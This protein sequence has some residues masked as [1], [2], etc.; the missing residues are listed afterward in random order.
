LSDASDILDPLETMPSN[1]DVFVPVSFPKLPVPDG[2]T[3][4]PSPVEA[5]LAPRTFPSEPDPSAPG[6]PLA[7]PEPPS[8]KANQN[9]IGFDA[10][11]TGSA[12]F[13]NRLPFKAKRR[14][15]SGPDIILFIFFFLLPLAAGIGYFAFVAADQYESEFRF[16]VV[17]TASATPPITGGL[18]SVLGGTGLSSGNTDSYTVTDFLVSPQAVTEVEKKLPLR[19]MFSN[20]QADWLFRLNPDVPQEKLNKYWQWMVASYYDPVTGIASARVRAFTA[21]DAH[22]IANALLKSAEALVNEMQERQRNDTIRFAQEALDRDNASLARIRRQ[23]LELRQQS[24][25]IE[26]AASGVAENTALATSLRMT[27]VTDQTEVNALR[28]VIKNDNAPM[29][30]SLMEKIE[31]AKEQLAI[32]DKEISTKGG[33]GPLAATVGKFDDLNAEQGIATSMMASDLVTL[34]QARAQADQQHIYLSA[35]VVPTNPTSSGFPDRPL[36]IA[37]TILSAF[38]LFCFVKLV[39]TAIRSHAI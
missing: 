34:Q 11:V 32:I 1:P 3:I 5:L 13:S 39:A 25:Y 30:R 24:G 23:M 16:N 28:G 9:P 21:S 17:D 35:Y 12:Q 4:F 37:L 10:T 33:S 2:S 14:W 29:I 20:P 31:A 8:G 18:A 19:E 36:A 26:P 7:A 6:A 15:P 27:I 22:E 38:G